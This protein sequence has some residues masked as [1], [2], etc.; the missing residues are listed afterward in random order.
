MPDIYEYFMF[1]MLE[2]KAEN[3]LMRPIKL[4]FYA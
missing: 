3:K 4:F 2:N 1:G